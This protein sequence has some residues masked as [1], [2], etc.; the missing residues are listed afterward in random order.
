MAGFRRR[1]QH[2]GVRPLAPSRTDPA[3]AWRRFDEACALRCDVTFTDERKSQRRWAASALLLLSRDSDSRQR[4]VGWVRA[5]VAEHYR[6]R[7][8]AIAGRP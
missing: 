5:E 8:N 2:R 3:T 6:F 1:R 7:V 4:R